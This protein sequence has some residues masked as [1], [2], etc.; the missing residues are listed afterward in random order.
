MA[1]GVDDA[2]VAGARQA[3]RLAVTGEAR[4]AFNVAAEPVIDVPVIAELLGQDRT[5]T[6]QGGTGRALSL[7]APARRAH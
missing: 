2:A 6:W 1:E 4:G 3:Y 5:C 7:V